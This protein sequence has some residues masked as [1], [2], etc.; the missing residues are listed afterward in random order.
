MP[1]PD[2]YS[3][4]I[5]SSLSEKYLANGA[6][7]SDFFQ[8]FPSDSFSNIGLRNSEMWDSHHNSF[9]RLKILPNRCFNMPKNSRVCILLMRTLSAKA[10]K[11]DTPSAAYWTG[12][13]IQTGLTLRQYRRIRISV[14]KSMRSPTVSSRTTDSA[15]A[16]G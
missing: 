11:W 10:S 4:V 9:Y 14:S 13:L 1:F 5:S 16:S 12:V 15:G 7:S 3:F 6:V 8:T 2:S